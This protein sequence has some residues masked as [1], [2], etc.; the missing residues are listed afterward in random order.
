MIYFAWKP[1]PSSPI[2]SACS[3]GKVENLSRVGKVSQRNPSRLVPGGAE[4]IQ[5]SA[6]CLP[7]SSLFDSA[8]DFYD[9]IRLA[10]GGW[11]LLV[12]NAGTEVSG[13]LWGPRLAAPPSGSA[14]ALTRSIVRATA[15]IENR[16]RL[17]LAG[18]NQALLSWSHSDREHLP[19]VYATVRQ[20][21]VGARM[22]IC[23]AGTATAY[24]RRASGDATVVG[25][26][27]TALGRCA[28]PDLH[29][30]RVVLRA[31]DSLVLVTGAVTN[32]A[33]PTGRRTFGSA[34]LGPF[35]TGLA[36]A[37]AARTADSLLRAVKEFSGGRTD[38]DTVVVVV[39]MPGNR[40]GRGMHAAA[41]PG[42]RSYSQIAQAPDDT[43][44]GQLRILTPEA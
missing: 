42:T 37:S 16:P 21:R 11:G 1:R 12:G 36:G 34:R 9:V 43:D 26:S 7:G 35:L 24:L 13:R 3:F 30:D 32:A 17:V 33:S 38:R 18:L 10:D 5:I 20:G 6:R 31:G 15:A 44:S 40:S 28:D 39:K 27:G 22:R 41:W 14:V 4:G 19:V 25:S 2:H 8:G 23:A 29:D